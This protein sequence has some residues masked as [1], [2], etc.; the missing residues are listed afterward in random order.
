VTG[1]ANAERRARRL[2]RW[3][4]Q[5]WRRRYGEEFVELLIA[6]I[7]ER[8]R[9]PRRTLDVARQ[10]LAARFAPRPALAAL[11]LVAALSLC[12]WILATLVTAPGDW[13]ALRCGRACTPIEVELLRQHEPWRVRVLYSPERAIPLAVAVGLAGAALAFLIRRPRGRR[14]QDSA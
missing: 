12:A 3:Y 7:E 4:P 2:L 11:V 1:R 5:A 8:P 14:P 13:A 9:S 6:D 10:G